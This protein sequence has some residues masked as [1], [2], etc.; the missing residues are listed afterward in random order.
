VPAV[1]VL[2]ASGVV[3]KAMVAPEPKDVIEAVASL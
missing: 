3:R 2:D 1:Y